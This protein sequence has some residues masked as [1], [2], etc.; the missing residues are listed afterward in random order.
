MCYL[1]RDISVLQPFTVIR[2][3]LATGKFGEFVIVDILAAG[4]IGDFVSL[5]KKNFS[6]D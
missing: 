1:C 6:V 3:I 2:D 4:K 5:K